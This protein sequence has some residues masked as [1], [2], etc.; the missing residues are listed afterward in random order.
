MSPDHA[1]PMRGGCHTTSAHPNPE[2]TRIFDLLYFHSSGVYK[3]PFHTL[4]S[5]IALGKILGAILLLHIHGICPTK[6]FFV[7]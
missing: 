1:G 2:Q 6:R 3:L 5:L 4:I 7:V